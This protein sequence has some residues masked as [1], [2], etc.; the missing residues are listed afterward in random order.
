MMLSGVSG[1]SS[2]VV[3]LVPGPRRCP[4]VRPP[5][6]R[7]PRGTSGAMLESGSRPTTMLGSDPSNE[8]AATSALARSRGTEV[9][10]R[11][12]SCAPAAS[13]A[14]RDAKRTVRVRTGGSGQRLQV[15]SRTKSHPASRT[16]RPGARRGGGDQARDTCVT[17]LIREPRRPSDLHQA[18]RVTFG[19]NL[20]RAAANIVPGKHVGSLESDP[21]KVYVVRS[22]SEALEYYAESHVGGLP[23]P[24][25]TPLGP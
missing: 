9:V 7:A 8:C 2:T 24:T 4:N 3:W 13:S 23:A 6:T 11:T 12:N 16:K 5:N 14:A 22:V 15:F 18:R 10:S 21:K 25:E 17:I 1:T 19:E 20:V